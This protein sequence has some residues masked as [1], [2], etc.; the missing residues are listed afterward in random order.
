[1]TDTE[2]ERVQKVLAN[3]GLGSRREIEQWIREGRVRINGRL[4][5]L[6]DRVG[7]EDQ[8]KLDGKPVRAE[9]I[10]AAKTNHHIIMYN[11]PEG[12]IVSRTDPE[13]RKTVFTR[14]PTLPHGRWIAVG[15]L[16]INSSGLL[17]LTTDGELANRLMHPSTQ[18][19]REYAVRVLGK[20]NSQQLQQLVNGVEL[21]DGFAR[22]EDIVESGG[23]GLNH[24]YHVVI[25][26]GRN[27]EVR[28][29]WDAVGLLVNR[30]KRVRFGPIILDSKVKVGQWRELTVPERRALLTTAGLKDEHYNVLPQANAKAAPR[31]TVAGTVHKPARTTKKSVWRR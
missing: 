8:L 4:A 9:R 31:K 22:F 12:E 15:R 7:D 23:E 18:I 28:R 27:R 19:E 26:E 14:L 1:M 21:D 6:G 17:L 10:Q 29:L 2:K 5:Q 13:G 11:K 30:L 24:W 16:D 20:A 25:M 3:A